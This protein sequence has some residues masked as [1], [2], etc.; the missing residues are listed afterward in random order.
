MIH[1]DHVKIYESKRYLP[2]VF[3]EKLLTHNMASWSPHDVHNESNHTSNL[4]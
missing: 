4:N 3:H 2:E 1:I